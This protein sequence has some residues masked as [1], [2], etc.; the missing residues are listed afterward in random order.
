MSNHD[1][2]EYPIGQRIQFFRNQ[3]GITTNKLANM[4]G[5]SQSYLRDLE[6]DNKNPT[7]EIV[8]QLCKALGITLNDFFN[9]DYFSMFSK[10]P[11]VT[12]IYRLTP[13]QRNAL[14]AF[15]ETFE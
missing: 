7:I 3:K 12:R 14:L 9:D 11:L 4:A 1:A 5:I 8:F 6:L 15:L 2:Y 10:D 13:E